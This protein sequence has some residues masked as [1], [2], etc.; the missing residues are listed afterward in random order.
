[1]R[2]YPVELRERVVKAVE[3]REGSIEAVAKIFS[4]GTTF[5]YKMLRQKEE[6]GSLSPK[7][8][9][10]GFAPLI[11]EPEL[12]EL[13]HLV[14]EQ[15]DATLEEFRDRLRQRAQVD[16]SL[17]MV[18]R[19]LQKLSLPRK[20]KRFF[21]QERNAKKRRAFRRK[22]QKLEPEKFVFIDEMGANI[23]LSRRYARAPKGQRVEEAL[24]QNTPTNVSVAGALGARKLLAACCIEGAFDGEAFAA[25][26]EQMVVPQLELGQT[27]LM[28]NVP[29]HQAARVESAIKS[30]EA[31][32][33]NLP[34]YSP[35]LDPMEPCWS[36]IKTYLR[37]A[38]AR[39][40]EAL[41][42]AIGL[43]MRLVTAED[44]RGWFSHAG[45]NFAPG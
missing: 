31:T 28:D 32:L 39:T 37:K 36:K 7:P 19:A 33:L 6:T 20:Q 41:Y 10:G 26:I 4:V 1:M 17:P 42:K 45:Y 14:E 9:G 12:K 30:A 44:I 18:C 8:H 16:A 40:L 25:F 35:D 29:T 34:A 13:R 21:A 22:V 38:K 3:E 2:S 5:I 24:P 27:V 43:G 11:D 15:P 23:N